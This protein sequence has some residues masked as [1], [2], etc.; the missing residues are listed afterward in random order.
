MEGEA[1]PMRE[2]IPAPRAKTTDTPAG[3]EVTIPARRNLFIVLFLACWLL[4]WAWGEVTVSSQVGREGIKGAGLFIIAWLAAWTLVGTGA[5]FAWCWQI[6]GREH[7]TL[8]SDSLLVRYEI[9][10]IGLT[11][12]YGLSDVKSLRVSMPTLDPTN[13]SAAFRFWGFGGGPIAFDFGPRTIRM[14]NG[15]DEAEA[16]SIVEAFSARH[17]FATA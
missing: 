4:G 9:F 5:I 17:A 12:E 11:R 8:A 10:S 16:R 1:R 13:P 6:A 2:R 3:L 14:G 15:L 7:I